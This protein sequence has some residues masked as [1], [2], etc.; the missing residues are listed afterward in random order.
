MSQSLY[1]CAVATGPI[2]LAGQQ[3]FFLSVRH[4]PNT[5]RSRPSS[6]SQLFT[7]PSWVLSTRIPNSST[8]GIWASCF[9]Q[10]FTERDYITRKT[11]WRKTHRQGEGE[12]CH[13]RGLV[14][15]MTDTTQATKFTQASAHVYR[16]LR[17][18]ESSISHGERTCFT[19]AII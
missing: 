4:K 5:L 15:P 19:F 17:Y 16:I 13:R 18:H 10:N 3:V 14:D 9:K 2:Y 6:R 7:I 8:R 1:V 11:E 12:R